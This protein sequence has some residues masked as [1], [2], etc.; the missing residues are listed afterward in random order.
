MKNLK[1]KDP[2]AQVEKIVNFLGQ[3]YQEQGKDQA[4]IA[5]SGGIDSSLALALLTQALGVE[6]IRPLMLPYGKQ[7]TV[8][9]ELALNFNQIPEENWRQINIKLAVDAA[10]AELEVGETE[11]AEIKRVRLGNIMA[12]VRMMMIY[13]VAKEMGGLVCGTENKSEKYLGYFTRFGD[14]ASDL[15]PLVHLYKTQVWQ[16]ARF[17]ELPEKIINQPP[18]AG[19]WDGQTDEEE[20][21]FSYE[22]VDQVLWQLVEEGREPDEIEIEGVSAIQVEAV[23]E[24]VERMEFKHRVPYKICTVRNRTTSSSTRK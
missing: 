23:V 24:R 1:L 13:D 18:S 14:E 5:V 4:V 20:L 16:L 12:R 19:L 6:K 17:L 15:E 9:A 21:G 3:T 7:N 22:V 11:V 8:D 10:A 2:A